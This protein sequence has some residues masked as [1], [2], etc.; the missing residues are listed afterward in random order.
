MFTMT[1]NE[2]NNNGKGTYCSLIIN[3]HLFVFFTNKQLV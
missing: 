2:F 3:S 1:K